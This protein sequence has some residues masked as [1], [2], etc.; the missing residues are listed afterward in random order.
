MLRIEQHRPSDVVEESVKDDDVC[1]D[2]A[3]DFAPVK[4]P[5]MKPTD[6]IWRCLR[7]SALMQRVA[8]G[9]ISARDL[10]HMV[11]SS[12]RVADEVRADNQS[13]KGEKWTMRHAEWRFGRF[14][15]EI[16]YHLVDN[17]SFVLLFNRVEEVGQMK[18]RTPIPDTDTYR[19]FVQIADLL[20]SGV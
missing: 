2:S 11:D 9:V 8:A 5:G 15:F 13:V 6:W 12:L 3:H 16:V 10:N 1:D 20:L 19:R 17:D 7:C 14:W 4:L 18:Q